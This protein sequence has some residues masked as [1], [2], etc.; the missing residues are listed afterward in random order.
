MNY[1]LV[2]TMNAGVLTSQEVLM[3]YFRPCCQLRYDQINQSELQ[4]TFLR[5]GEGL[6]LNSTTCVLNVKG[7]GFFFPGR[8][9]Q[10]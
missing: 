1:I 3:L 7:K 2:Q 8:A 10:K 9:M 4:E 6:F 5:G